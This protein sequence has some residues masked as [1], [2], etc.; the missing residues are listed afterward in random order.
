MSALLR[1]GCSSNIS[2]CDRPS[3]FTDAARYKSSLGLND[4]EWLTD[5]PE[6]PVRHRGRTIRSGQ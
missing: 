5:I 3:S 2:D 6:E 1:H 4:N